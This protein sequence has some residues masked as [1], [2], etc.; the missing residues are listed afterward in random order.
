MLRMTVRKRS[1]RASSSHEVIADS[2]TADLTRARGT[3][4]RLVAA[5]RAAKAVL[6]HVNEVEKAQPP[7]GRNMR[8]LR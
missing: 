8:L 1:H 4:R 7:L 2:S 3:R 6:E 5:S